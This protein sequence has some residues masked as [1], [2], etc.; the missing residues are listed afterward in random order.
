[1]AHMATGEKGAD[2]ASSGERALLATSG[3]LGNEVTP[4]IFVNDPD[5]A[6]ATAVTLGLAGYL[7]GAR[8]FIDIGDTDGVLELG[9]GAPLRAVASTLPWGAMT[10]IVSTGRHVP[11]LAG[12]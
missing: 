10:S 2:G 11:A 1:M 6:P 7:A 9:C 12:E 4:Q 3:R 5:G 8:R